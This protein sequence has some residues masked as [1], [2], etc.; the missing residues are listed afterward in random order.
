MEYA[1][2]KEEFC[3]LMSNFVERYLAREDAIDKISSIIDIN[4]EVFYQ[5]DFSEMLVDL[6]SDVLNDKN[7]WLAYF[8]YE[9]KCHWFYYWEDKRPFY[10]NSFEKLYDLITTGSIVVKP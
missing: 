2:K 5:F 1:L 7:G 9:M 8:V 4:F 6:L 10:V 3:E